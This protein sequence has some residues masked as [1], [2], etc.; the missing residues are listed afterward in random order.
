MPA[1]F[2]VLFDEQLQ[3][4]DESIQMALRVELGRILV[5][6]DID[7]IAD[8]E[9]ESLRSKGNRQEPLSCMN[10]NNAV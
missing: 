8:H 6:S 7:W 2:L 5:A 3:R 1:L 4:C 10:K 9:R